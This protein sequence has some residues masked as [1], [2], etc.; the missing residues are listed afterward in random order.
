MASKPWMPLYV[1]DYLAD[2]GHLSVSEHGAY[3]LLIMHYWQKGGLPTE[4]RLLARICRMLPDEWA[5]SRDVLQ[6][7]FSDAWTHKRIDEELSK[8]DDISSKRRAAAEQR[9]SKSDASAPANG[10]AI[11]EQKHTQSQSQSPKRDA[12]ASQ[13]RAR[14]AEF[15]EWYSE[16]PHKVQR[17]AARKAFDK[18]R[19]KADLTTL[20]AGV[21][22]YKRSKNPDY[23]WRNP[24][25]WLNS[26][27]WLDQPA[28]PAKTGDP[29]PSTVEK[30][31]VKRGDPRFEAAARYCDIQRN[32][33]DSKHR[34]ELEFPKTWMR[35]VE[36]EQRKIDE[37][38]QWMR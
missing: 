14:D 34:A 3:M 28:I 27:S 33:T 26:E 17:A 32:T 9:H 16:Y 1:A 20:K 30:I 19:E 35:G 36:E 11:A 21:E 8:A 18:A 24:A 4:D 31:V 15:E 7:L 23:N 22:A 37:E 2:T 29:P 13:K 25:T 38:S 6:D 12:N 10:H 5:E